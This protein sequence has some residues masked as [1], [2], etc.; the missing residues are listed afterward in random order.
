M[1][2]GSATRLQDPAAPGAAAPA[3]GHRIGSRL[4]QPTAGAAAQELPIKCPVV[5]ELATL[6]QVC[7][8]SRVPCFALSQG[9]SRL[10]LGR[11]QKN[12]GRIKG[13]LQALGMV[14]A[15]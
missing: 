1:T 12:Q 4:A 3:P 8:V 6:L 7:G 2:S 9:R 14:H 5:F 10:C 13:V 15:A 11:Q